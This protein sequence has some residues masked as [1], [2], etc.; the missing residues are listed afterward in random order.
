MYHKGQNLQETKL[1]K[2]SKE[3]IDVNHIYFTSELVRILLQDT[4]SE[5]QPI[6]NVI[7]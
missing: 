4:Y 3:L 6:P 2:D 7:S 1:F 5:A